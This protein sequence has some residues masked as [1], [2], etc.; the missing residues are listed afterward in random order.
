MLLTDDKQKKSNVTEEFIM[1]FTN[2]NVSD[3]EETNDEEDVIGDFHSDR[4]VIGAEKTNNRESSRAE[5]IKKLPN[6]VNLTKFN[7]KPGTSKSSDALHYCSTAQQYYVRWREKLPFQDLESTTQRKR[8]VSV[9]QKPDRS[10][11]KTIAPGG[12]IRKITESL[13]NPKVHDS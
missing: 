10:R 11:E 12:K 9:P 5:M 8:C 7:V 1:N 6:P 13:E 2:V 3:D 4:K